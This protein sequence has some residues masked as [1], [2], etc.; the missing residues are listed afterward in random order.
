VKFSSTGWTTWKLRQ[1]TVSCRVATAEVMGQRWT[2]WTETTAFAPR[3]TSPVPSLGLPN[4][5]ASPWSDPPSPTQ[6]VKVGNGALAVETKLKYFGR[7]A[8]DT[9]RQINDPTQPTPLTGIYTR[10]AFLQIY[11]FRPM[12]EPNQLRKNILDPLPTQPNPRVNQTHG[13]FWLF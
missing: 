7:R 3:R 2:F 11:R 12:T 13:Q 1:V 5:Q 9:S 4:S 8:P 6:P 10:L